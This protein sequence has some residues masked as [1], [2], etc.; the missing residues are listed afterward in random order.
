MYDTSETVEPSM[1]RSLAHNVYNMTREKK[2]HLFTG[3]EALEDS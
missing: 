2:I 3:S 1:S